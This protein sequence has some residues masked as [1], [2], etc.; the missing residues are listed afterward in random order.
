MRHAGRAARGQELLEN[1][2]LSQVVIG[3]DDTAEGAPGVGVHAQSL[4]QPVG[5]RPVDDVEGERELLPHLV[6]PLQPQGGRGQDEHSLYPPA[7]KQLAQDQARLDGLAYP[8]VIGDEQVHA[9]H[10]QGLEQRHQL[11][12]LDLDGAVEGARDGQPVQG[13][14][15]IGI[16]VGQVRNI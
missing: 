15:A 4:A 6:S 16:E 12:V 3:G 8:H 7:Q 1:V 10:T 5:F 2:L 13:P 9:R 14:L 11:V